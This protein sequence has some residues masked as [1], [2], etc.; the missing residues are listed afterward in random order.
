[1]E[2]KEVLQKRISTRAFLNKTIDE[3]LLREIV[4]AALYAPVGL[5]KYSEMLITVVTDKRILTEI[6]ETCRRIPDVSPLHG[7]PALII[8]S[9]STEDEDLRNQNAAC[10]VENMLLAATNLNLA[11]LY[12]KCICPPLRRN[13]DLKKSLHIP[14]GF[15]PLASAAIGYPVTDT[16]LRESPQNNVTPV[17]FI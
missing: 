5:K 4:T 13:Q 16:E 6:D 9:A 1:M 3:N 14:S 2:L 8:V 11:G 17:V 7:A 15:V 12:I 10:M